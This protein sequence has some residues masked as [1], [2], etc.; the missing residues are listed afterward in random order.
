MNWE[1]STEFQIPQIKVSL[2]TKIH[3]KKLKLY[4]NYPMINHQMDKGQLSNKLYHYRIINNNNNNNNIR[5]PYMNNAPLV[6][7]NDFSDYKSNALMINVLPKI[8]K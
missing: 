2:L 8:R 1:E 5:I 3:L 7:S 6:N 4:Q